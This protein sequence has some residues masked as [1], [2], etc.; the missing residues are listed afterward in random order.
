MEDEQTEG[1]RRTKV[2][3]ERLAQSVQALEGLTEK[4]VARVVASVEALVRDLDELIEKQPK[5]R[6]GKGKHAA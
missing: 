2:L 3:A 6:A 1:L 4:R 5:P